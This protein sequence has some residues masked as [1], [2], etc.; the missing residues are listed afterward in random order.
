F[1]IGPS[2]VLHKY[3]VP[4][5]HYLGMIHIY[6]ARTGNGRFLFRGTYIYVYLGTRATWPLI[7]HFPKIIL[8]IPEQYSILVNNG[9][10]KIQCLGI[11]FQVVRILATFKN[12][13]I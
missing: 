5:L 12:G 1:T 7:A 11:L 8:F 6:Q 10:P 13:N 3:Q 9:P 2:I 4:Y